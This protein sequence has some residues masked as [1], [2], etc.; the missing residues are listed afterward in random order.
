MLQCAVKTS[1]L[2]A[3]MHEAAWACDSATD[4]YS[5]RPNKNAA[6]RE[7][8]DPMCQCD[9]HLNSSAPR[10]SS[11]PRD[12]PLRRDGQPPHSLTKRSVSRVLIYCTVATQSWT[13]FSREISWRAPKSTRRPAFIFCLLFSWCASPALAHSRYPLV[14]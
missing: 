2:V 12:D 8:W 5:W 7:G 9:V 13:R 1:W 6:K 3:F 11:G 14:T 10:Q 4:W